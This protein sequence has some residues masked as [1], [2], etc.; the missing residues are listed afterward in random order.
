[1]RNVCVSVR[2]TRAR[3]RSTTVVG[4]RRAASPVGRC[5]CRLRSVGA[6]LMPNV[7]V[8]MHQPLLS[9][10]KAL[11]PPASWPG[12]RSAHGHLH[13]TL[14]RLSSLSFSLTAI[15]H[16]YPH[17]PFVSL[18]L[19]LSLSLA[20]TI[21]GLKRVRVRACGRARTCASWKRTACPAMRPRRW[22]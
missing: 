10:S 16:R 13:P 17:Y 3:V 8:P 5:S 20:H 4:C 18:S 21:L 1:M 7:F 15:P 11:V 6:V 9:R 2:V 22:E 12:I 19:S 14:S